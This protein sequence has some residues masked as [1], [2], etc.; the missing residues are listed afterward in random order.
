[1]EGS[2]APDQPDEQPERC[3]AEEGENGRAHV[4]DSGWAE[5][6]VVIL[7]PPVGSAPL[8]ASADACPPPEVG[9]PPLEATDRDPPFP[10][11]SSPS[12]AGHLS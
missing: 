2:Q 5:G 4:R 6:G 11:P 3:Q 1:M 9:G 8:A 12:P 10:S 7:G